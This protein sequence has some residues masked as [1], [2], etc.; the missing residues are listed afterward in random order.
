MD[1]S[2]APAVN[3]FEQFVIDAQQPEDPLKVMPSFR[4][5]FQVDDVDVVE[6]QFVSGRIINGIGQQWVRFHRRKMI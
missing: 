4:T 3:S 6:T 2:F 1:E 5:P